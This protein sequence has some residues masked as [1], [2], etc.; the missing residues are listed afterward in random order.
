MVS[1][2]LTEHKINFIPEYTLGNLKNLNKSFTRLDFGIINKNK[3]LIG[4]IEVNGVQHYDIN[5]P[6]YNQGVEDNLQLKQEYCHTNNI[7]FLV[8]NYINK[9]LNKQKVIDFIQQFKEE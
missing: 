3:Q 5:N 6:W 7:P 9:N 1:K 2:I 4:A 8:I